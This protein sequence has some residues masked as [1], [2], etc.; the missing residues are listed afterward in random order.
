MTTNYTYILTHHASRFVIDFKDYAKCHGIQDA[1]RKILTQ[2][3]EFR[4]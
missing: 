4:A 1:N 2:S 3:F